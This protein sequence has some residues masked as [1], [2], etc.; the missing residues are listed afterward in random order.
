MKQLFLFLLVLIFSTQ[1]ILSQEKELKTEKSPQEMYDFYSLKH[2]KLKRTGFII[3]GAGVGAI[4]TGIVITA[5]ADS[6][7]GVFIFLA[8]ATT[9]FASI[10]VFIV[11]K[12]KKR[13]AEAILGTGK[14]GI[15]G[16]SFDNS[17]YV[18]VGLK[19]NF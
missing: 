16:V 12:S 15:E 14:I 13:K 17:R 5:T 3:L 9:T 6:Y 4:I 2:K 19:I 10:P 1:G 7:D 11:A 18:S 8:G